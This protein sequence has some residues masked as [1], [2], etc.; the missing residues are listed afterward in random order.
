MMRILKNG[1]YNNL[2]GFDFAPNMIAR[3]GDALPWINLQKF[4][5]LVLSRYLYAFNS[6]QQ[7]QQF[8]FFDRGIIDS[9]QLSRNQIIS[10]MLLTSS[11]TIV[12]CF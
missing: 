12:L 8:I 11:S 6:Q 7:S 2:L 10:K 3:E 5:D 4:L 1:G 9:L